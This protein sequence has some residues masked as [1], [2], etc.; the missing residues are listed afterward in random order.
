MHN[1]PKSTGW[2][3]PSL[4][5]DAACHQRSNFQHPELQFSHL[6]N[7]AS[8]TSPPY[9]TEISQRNIN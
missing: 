1:R 7:E 4:A 3:A 9:F 8:N 2:A 6:E 5:L